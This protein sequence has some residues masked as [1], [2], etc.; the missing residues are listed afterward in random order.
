MND[1]KIEK[2]RVKKELREFGLIFGLGITLLFGLFFPWLAEKAIPIWPPA[3]ALVFASIALILPIIL[4][5]FHWL[6]MKIGIVL[7]WINTR[8]ILTIIFFVVLFPIGLIMRL[9]SDPMAR[10]FDEK[11]YSYRILTDSSPSERLKRPF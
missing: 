1:K 3:I 11:T 6:W 10:N 7:G 8:I 5:P 4:K 9:F 2:A